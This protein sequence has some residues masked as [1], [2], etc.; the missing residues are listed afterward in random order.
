[1]SAFRGGCCRYLGPGVGRQVNLVRLGRYGSSAEQWANTGLLNFSEGL[2]LR[3]SLQ[4]LDNVQSC[5]EA[6][7]NSQLAHPVFLQ[8]PAG[9][10]IELGML[11]NKIVA[12]VEL[13][14]NERRRG[15][16]DF[17]LLFG[18][19]RA[20]GQSPVE[21]GVPDNERPG[22]VVSVRSR[23]LECFFGVCQGLSAVPVG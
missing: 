6:L 1:V 15:V 7:L 10:F 18:A 23:H 5:E 4:A 17:Y 19:R 13:Q 22:K 3:F 8:V 16:E 14:A 2:S 9:V 12:T 20:T 21:V 11:F